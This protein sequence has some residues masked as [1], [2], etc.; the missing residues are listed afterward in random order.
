MYQTGT[1]LTEP[2]VEE[3][4]EVEHADQVEAEAHGG[5]DHVLRDGV[6]DLGGVL[7]QQR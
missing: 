7:V 4:E 2:L 6:A 3:E 5:A 1:P